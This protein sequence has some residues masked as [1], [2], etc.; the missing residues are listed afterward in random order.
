MAETAA[1]QSETAANFGYTLAFFNSNPELKALLARATSQSY[2]TARF[3]AELQNTKWFRTSS[4]S[5]RKYQALSQGDPATFKSQVDSIAARLMNMG[6]EI[7]A[8]LAQ[9]TANRMAIQAMQLGWT[10]DQMR[11]MLAGMIYTQNGGDY[12]G[13]AGAYQQQFNEMAADYGLTISG[14]T[15]RGW[16][17][18]AVLGARDPMGV[19]QSLQRIAASKYVALKDRIMEGETVREIADPYIQSY[20][21]TLEINP[22]Q[23]GL[24]DNLIQ[25]ALQSKDAKGQPST[26]TLYEFEQTLRNDPR[27]A[28]TSN[29]QD[30]VMGTANKILQTFGLSA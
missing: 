20:A 9:N 3:V 22:E 6:G 13:K 14:P 23:V 11:R 18:D 2:S 8:P 24:D 1:T 21:K 27:W 17:R 15:M 7:G 28:K 16:V 19:K 10:D 4:E 25:Q 29:A 12:S 26:Q 30:L 5:M